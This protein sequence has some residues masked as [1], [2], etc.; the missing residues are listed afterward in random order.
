MSQ[1]GTDTDGGANWFRPAGVLV[2]WLHSDESDWIQIEKIVDVFRLGLVPVI[3][4]QISPL[5]LDL[6]LDLRTNV[7]KQQ[8]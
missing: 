2:M 6:S 7:V 8:A 1:R 5:S 4:H 3:M